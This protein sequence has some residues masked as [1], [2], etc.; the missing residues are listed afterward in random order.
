MNDYNINVDIMT[1]NFRH[2]RLPTWTSLI[3]QFGYLVVGNGWGKRVILS[4]YKFNFII[5][6]DNLV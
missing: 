5:V 6:H 3:D 1:G 2:F 4:S